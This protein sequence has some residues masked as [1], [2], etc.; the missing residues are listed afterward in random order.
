MKRTFSRLLSSVALCAVLASPALAQMQGNGFQNGIPV[1]P[2]ISGA[3]DPLTGLY[4]GTN[5]LGMS[6]HIGTGTRAN[7]VPVLSAC[8][9]TVAP[10][11]GST[12]SAGTATQ[13]GTVTT[14]TITF[15]TPFAV[16]PACIVADLTGTRASMASVASTTAITITG[17]TAADALAWVCVAKSGG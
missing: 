7:T 3:V 1:A 11:A 12:D 10:D 14:C 16:K 13:G 2:G 15:G 17:I 5:L 9:G 8:G 4:F 6:G